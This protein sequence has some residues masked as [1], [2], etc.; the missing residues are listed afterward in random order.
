MLDITGRLCPS[1][2]IAMLPT[3]IFICVSVKGWMSEKCLTPWCKKFSDLRHWIPCT[4]FDSD[5]KEYNEICTTRE[6]MPDLRILRSYATFSQGNNRQFR[7]WLSLFIHSFSANCTKN[8]LIPTN[9][10]RF[11]FMCKCVM[12][13]LAI[14]SIVT[15]ICRVVAMVMHG[16][17]IYL[18]RCLY[19]EGSQ[20]PANLLLINLSVSELLFNF[21]DVLSTPVSHIKPSY[22]S[23][24]L[25]MSPVLSF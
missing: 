23:Q 25:L 6:L 13:S 12:V 9:Q 16:L 21:F 5:S 2:P 24:G 18:L 7:Q 11:P 14:V 22:D 3:K 20:A 8:L 4:K 17:G 10:W 15:N 1:H 19:K